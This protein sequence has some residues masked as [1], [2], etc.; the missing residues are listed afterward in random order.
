MSAGDDDEPSDE[1]LL[2]AYAQGDAAAFERLY[3]R[4]L[5]WAQQAE[6]LYAPP[7][8]AS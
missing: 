7:E 4:Y 1:A 8:N 2:R 6:P 5:H 3:Q